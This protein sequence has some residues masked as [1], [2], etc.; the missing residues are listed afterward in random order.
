MTGLQEIVADVQGA[1]IQQTILKLDNTIA[2]VNEILHSKEG[3][4]GMLLNDKTLHDDLTTAIQNLDHAV[5]NV[6]SIV[7]S[8][9][10]RPFIQ[11]KLP[12][13]K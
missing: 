8:I 1:D 12:K 6:D 13:N 10:A 5:L 3:T 4:L 2:K 11:K 9:K 7:M